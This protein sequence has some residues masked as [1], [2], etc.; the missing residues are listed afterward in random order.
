GGIFRAS[1][2]EIQT[3]AKVSNRTCQNAIEALIKM[4]IIE[5]YGHVDDNKRKACLWRFCDELLSASADYAKSVDYQKYHSS[6]YDT[7]PAVYC[8]TFNNSALAERGALGKR[9]YQVYDA[10]TQHEQLTVKELSELL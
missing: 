1:Y 10:L 2:R 9:G 7:T 3:K 6:I 4:G 5:K 8:A